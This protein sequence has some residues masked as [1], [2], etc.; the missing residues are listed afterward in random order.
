MDSCIFCGDMLQ[1]LNSFCDKEKCMLNESIIFSPLSHNFISKYREKN[2]EEY[3]FI[4][5]ILADAV[6]VNTDKPLWELYQDNKLIDFFNYN[7]DNKMPNRILESVNNLI[8]D[9]DDIL[10]TNIGMETYGILKYTIKNHSKSIKYEKEISDVLKGA[11][12]FSFHYPESYNLDIEEFEKKIKLQGNQYLFHGSS[13][14]NWGSILINGL[15]NYSKTSK[16]KNGNAF[17]NGIYLSDSISLSYSYSTR[18][19]I[20]KFIIG[21]FEVVKDD[22]YNKGSNVFVVP[23]EKNV[24]LKYLFR[25]KD[26]SIQNIKD[27]GDYLTKGR[28]QLK[29]NVNTYVSKMKNKRLLMEVN[30]IMKANSLNGIDYML[31]EVVDMMKWDI[32]LLNLDNE[33]ELFKD[34]KRMNLEEIV[35]EVKFTESYPIDPP[36]VRIIKPA[37]KRMTGHVTQG[38]GLCFELL[39]NQGWSPAVSM[40]SLII[41]IKTIISIDGRLEENQL[42]VKNYTE[43]EAVEGFGRAMRAHGWK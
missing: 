17:G 18:K 38:G 2:E 23:D 25:V 5:E 27:I 31:H 34:M 21:V 12:I 37:F 7:I 29:E 40:E 4:V 32:S 42:A 26:R 28:V 8:S 41:N 14:E 15:R 6:K 33:S 3:N 43:R 30:K 13:Y 16:M 10:H 24:R 22:T 39:T 36:K 20:D 19:S 1:N 35:I 9:E 11:K